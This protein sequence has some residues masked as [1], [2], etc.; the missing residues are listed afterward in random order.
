M[1]VALVR[2]IVSLDNDE[3]KITRVDCIERQRIIK[4]KAY[5]YGSKLEEVGIKIFNHVC[6]DKCECKNE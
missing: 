1:L 6:E 4:L 5:L 2:E 3:D